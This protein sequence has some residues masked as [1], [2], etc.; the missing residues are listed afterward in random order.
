V[1]L[2]PWRFVNLE[3]VLDGWEAAERPDAE[4][5]EA[6]YLWLM[7]LRDDPEPAESGPVPGLP[8]QSRLAQVPGTGVYFLYEIAEAEHQLW[9]VLMAS[10][11]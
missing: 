4:T 5:R 2:L 11:D 1:A 7:A 6:V 3:R 9:A 8:G 10:P